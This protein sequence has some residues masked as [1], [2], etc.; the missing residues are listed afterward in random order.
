MLKKYYLLS[1]GPTPVPETVLAKAAL[2]II[3][4][5]TEEFS[6]IFM[7]M[8][9]GMK[10]V[11]QTK[12]DVYTLTCSGT[13]AMESAVTNL[14][15]PG[16]KVLVIVGG[17]FGERWGQICKAYG[18]NAIEIPVEWGCAYPA[19]ELEKAL[20]ANPD[21]KAVL[22]QLSE[23]STGAVYDIEGFAKVVGKT[24]AIL[25]VDGI[26]GLGATPCPMDQWGVNVLLTGSQK[27]LMIPPGLAFISFDDKAWKLVEA[28]KLPKFYFDMKKAR[29]NLAKKTT[30][31]TPGV[32]LVIQQL[33]ALKIIN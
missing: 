16:D 29:K 24:D 25:V 4:H 19:E 2:P 10:Y 5:R 7:E 13:G 22:C 27:S 3:H 28:S 14:F 20:K 31:W 9:E 21:A 32:T 8:T 17:K 30:P 12:N 23:T 26:S 15:S 11:F 18:V 6:N 1:P 33:E